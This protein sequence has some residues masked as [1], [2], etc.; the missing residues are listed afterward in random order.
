MTQNSYTK[1][2]YCSTCT[3][4]LEKARTIITGKARCNSCKKK[5]YKQRQLERVKG[6]NQTWKRLLKTKSPNDIKY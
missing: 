3:K 5:L 6:G 4:P 2:Q 1:I